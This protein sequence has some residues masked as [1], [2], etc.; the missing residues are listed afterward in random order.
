M[1]ETTTTDAVTDGS[2]ERP[3]SLAD[4]EDLATFRETHEFALVEFYTDGCGICASMEPVL[5]GIAREP[6]LAVGL[7]NPREDPPLVDEF[8]VRSVP[9]LVLFRDGEVVDRR[10]DGFVGV[11]DLRAWLEDYRD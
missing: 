7:I 9:L 5:T 11:E 2:P 10:A 4:A 1:T 6:D 8:D 3:Q